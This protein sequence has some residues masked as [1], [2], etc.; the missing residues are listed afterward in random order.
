MSSLGTKL[1]I[2]SNGKWLQVFE[3][4][5]LRVVKEEVQEGL[6]QELFA[7]KTWALQ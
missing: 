4:A 3:E 2:R 7:V 6:P 5:G 1:T